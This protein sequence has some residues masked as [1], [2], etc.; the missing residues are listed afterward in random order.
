[1]LSV[2]DVQKSFDR[3]LA[4]KNA[5]LEVERGEIVAVIGPNGAGKSTLFGLIAGCL[6]PDKGRIIFKGK[7][8]GGLA[9]YLICR[10]GLKSMSFQIVNVFNRLTV[11]ETFRC[12]FFPV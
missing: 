9:S 2:K 7:D 11:F 5:N 4:V 3:F 8:I 1:M 12:L 6:A 10:R